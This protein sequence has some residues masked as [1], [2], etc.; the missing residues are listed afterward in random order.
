MEY[1]QH[2]YFQI[3]GFQV[4]TKIYNNSVVTLVMKISTKSLIVTQLLG[5]KYVKN[6]KIT[7]VYL[8]HIIIH[9][10]AGANLSV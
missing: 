6:T 4:K 10:N 3:H 5:K 8:S 7:Q 2:S 1:D 9:F